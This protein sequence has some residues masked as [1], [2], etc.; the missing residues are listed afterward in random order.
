MMAT[1]LLI[2]GAQKSCS[3][4]LA[5]MLGRHPLLS[6]A[7]REVVAFEDP[8]YPE[9][10]DEVRAHVRCSAAAGLIPALKR[11][12]LLHRAEASERALRHLPNPVVV[13]VLRE[14][15][16]RTVSAYHHYVSYGLLPAREA[17]A[18]ISAILD[19]ILPD[20]GPTIGSQVITYSLYSEPLRRLKAELGEHFLVFFQEDLLA[21]PAR[22]T[23]RILRQLDIEA[24]DLGTL[25]RV[26]VGDYSLNPMKL[27]R[28]GGRIGYDVDQEHGQ[29]RVTPQP[30]RRRTAQAL[31]FLDKLYKPRQT[32]HPTLSPEVRHRLVQHFA[33]DVQ[34]LSAIIEQ[35][36]PEAWASSVEL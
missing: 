17:N 15:V 2:A 22:C 23:T 20:K 34:R 33:D 30:V 11:P 13:V 27:S 12:E 32:I 31:F 35:P 25:P 16:A 19:E 21:D 8:Y 14:P 4:S 18:G 10:L 28:I 7:K 26:N 3:T 9:H 24:T 29:F 6:M 36:L 5:E 1:A